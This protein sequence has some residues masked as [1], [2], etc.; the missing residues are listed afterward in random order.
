MRE[1]GI[2]FQIDLTGGL[3]AVGIESESVSVAEKVIPAS[4][5]TPQRHLR[6][7]NSI[8]LTTLVIGFV[9]S[10]AAELGNK[11]LDELGTDLYQKRS[12]GLR[13]LDIG[14][15]CLIHAENSQLVTTFDHWFD[16]TGVLVRV[17]FYASQIWDD[18]PDVLLV[19]RALREAVKY[20]SANGVTHRVI[21]F[22]VRDGVLDITPQLLAALPEPGQL[23]P[24]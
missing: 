19:D 2:P 22:E 1:A 21:S 6:T 9:V 8:T 7:T 24:T 12:F 14:S 20:V 5:R 15:S 10:V 11:F 3:K 17:E 23:P 4:S 18:Q 13:W 16:Q